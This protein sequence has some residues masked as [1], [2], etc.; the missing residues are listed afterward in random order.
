[1]IGRETDGWM[2]GKS[3]EQVARASYTRYDVSGD[4]PGFAVVKLTRVG[5]CPSPEAG[6][7]AGDRADRPGGDR[8]RQA[9][10][11][12]AGDPDAAIRRA[13][14]RGQ[15]RHLSP[16]N[17]PWRLE[18]TIAPTFRPQEDRPVEERQP[19]TRRGDRRRRFQPLFEPV[20]ERDAA[21]RYVKRT[22]SARRASG[23]GA[24]ERLG[25]R[26]GEPRE[27]D[28]LRDEERPEETPP[29]PR[30]AEV[31]DHL[32]ERYWRGFRSKTSFFSVNAA[33]WRE[34][35]ATVA[36][37]VDR[38]EDRRRRDRRSGDVVV[39]VAELDLRT[40]AEAT[41]GCV[42][43]LRRRVDAA[44]AEAAREQELPETRRPHRRD[45]APRRPA[46]AAARASRSGRP[47]ARGTAVA[48]AYAF[49]VQSPAWRAYWSSSRSQR[50]QSFG[51]LADE[52]RHPARVPERVP[53][54]E[55]P[56]DDGRVVV[57][58]DGVGDVPALPAR[59]RRAVAEID[60]LAVV[61]VAR[62]PNRRSRRASSG[63]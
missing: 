62:R 37:V 41:R 15:R 19:P 31:R 40:P 39:E 28:R 14:L 2:I 4:G 50:E 53:R 5:W 21:T 11:D 42:D 23:P 44:V 34:E 59:L 1:M 54:E 58:H 3:G 25:E 35:R 30:G 56:V 46:R 20:Q 24:L 27:R 45:R 12:R 9:A 61:A 36:R 6:R 47:G 22:R 32:V 7:R 51:V 55:A 16:P 48:S 60:V 29:E 26:R 38:A 33:T 63:A 18:V 49:S 10:G 43:H 8:P 57:R 52:P 13:G 17:E